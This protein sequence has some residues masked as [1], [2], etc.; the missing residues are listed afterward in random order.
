MS[1]G[2]G[3]AHGVLRPKSKNARKGIET[4]PFRRGGGWSLSSPKSKNARKGIETRAGAS[5]PRRR[6]AGPKSKNARKGIETK[7][8]AGALPQSVRGP[9]SKNARKGIETFGVT[10]QVADDD[11]AVRKAKMPARALKLERLG[12]QENGEQA[13]EKQKCPQGH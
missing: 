7:P 10:T 2:P 4:R 13:S 12:V 11:N 1:V 9:K 5:Q 3:V 6:G 8:F